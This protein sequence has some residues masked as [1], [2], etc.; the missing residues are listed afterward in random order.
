MRRAIDELWTLPA[1]Y[2]ILRYN[3]VL[4]SHDTESRQSG[5]DRLVEGS[6]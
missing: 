6:Q 4:V 5:S 2:R 3:A 1:E